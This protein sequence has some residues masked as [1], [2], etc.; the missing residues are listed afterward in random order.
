MTP[1]AR[2]DSPLVIGLDVG[3]SSVKAAFFGRGGRRGAVGR[4]VIAR[5]ATDGLGTQAP[6]AVRDAV[7]GVLADV[8][9]GVEGRPDAL[10]LS[11][12]M[13]G[14]VGLDAHG[15]AVTPLV[16][17]ADDR[18]AGVVADW[19]R[20]GDADFV[21]GRTGVPLHPMAPIAKLA[22]FAETAPAVAAR[23]ACWA[24]LKALVVSWL[25]GDVVT[26]ASSA[27]G[28]GL[29]DLHRRRWDADAMGLA[30]VDGER[31]PPIASPT[32]TRP[33]SRETAERTG[34]ATGTPVVVGAGDGPLGNLGVGATAPGVAGVSLGTSGAVR[35]VVDRVP[36][37]L[38]GLFCY[39]L[40]EQRWV[41]GG[42]VS[43]GGNIVDWLADTLMDGSGEATAEADVDRPAAVTALAAA[44]PPGAAGLVMVPY[45][46]AE[47]AP[48]WDPALP[49]AYLGLG[50]RH[51]RA[52]L[53]R[54]AL[55][56]VCASLG[57]ITDRID[58]AVPVR[59]VRVTGGTMADPLWRRLLA[60]AL[61]RPMTVASSDEGSALGA[62]AMGFV[63][64][65]VV[66]D[67]VAAHDLIVGSTGGDADPVEVTPEL[68]DAARLVR[69]RIADATSAL[70]DLGTTYAPH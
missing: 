8:M 47:R 34:L 65:G 31:L 9:R 42:A 53:A 37:D 6:E 64:L 56:G 22:W 35:V 12:A 16:T 5:T 19:R 40:D 23:V 26:D 62:A 63:A 66:D 57:V 54:A 50:R 39:V 29:M 13:H 61:G 68:A 43:N 41:L 20:R 1:T 58:V 24:D 48:R 52:H 60:A 44:A 32:A 14:L 59:S 33:S 10:A 70:A 67:P 27:S 38:D 17:W 49:G 36:D 2:D 51:G 4:R 30:G 46:L 55:E 28:W 3:T 21:H 15:E 45:L 25:T 7:F 69:R 11:T 18:A